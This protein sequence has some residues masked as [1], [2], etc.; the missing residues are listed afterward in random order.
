M[1]KTKILS[2]LIAFCTMFTLSFTSL[3]KKKVNNLKEVLKKESRVNYDLKDVLKRD[4]EIDYLNSVDLQKSV[5]EGILES[6]KT[7]EEKEIGKAGFKFA[8]CLGQLFK[9]DSFWLNKKGEFKD[10]IFKNF[11][12]KKFDFVNYDKAVFEK[13]KTYFESAY[14]KSDS[15]LTKLCKPKK[16]LDEKSKKE[17]KEFINRGFENLI[18]QFR[19]FKNKSLLEKVKKDFK[20]EKGELYKKFIKDLEKE[21][22]N[23]R[24]NFSLSLKYLEKFKNE[25]AFRTKLNNKIKNFSLKDFFEGIENPDNLLK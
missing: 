14:K 15:M 16:N 24:D 6:L 19:M 11:V 12:T 2:V 8:L 10:F 22:R 13:M 5:E 3:A 7:K 4:Y 18:L 25:K 21:L 1:R 17:L 23:I 20:N 9:K